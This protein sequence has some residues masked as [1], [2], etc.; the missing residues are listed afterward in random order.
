MRRS[1]IWGAA[2]G[3]SRPDSPTRGVAAVGIDLSPAM[4]AAG[5]RDY[6]QA[7]F[8]VGDMLELPAAEGE[9]G[10]AIGFYSIIHLEA[11]ELPRAFG[12]IHRVLR[13]GGL[14]LVA[15]HI[16]AEVLTGQLAR[17]GARSPGCAPGGWPG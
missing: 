7:E 2:R 14:F 3:T 1:P 13:P 10:A 5:R 17:P 9:L 6:P 11:A 8:R 4:I 12:E 16:G 15:F